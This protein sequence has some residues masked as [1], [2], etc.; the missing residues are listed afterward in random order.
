M[1]VLILSMVIAFLTTFLVTKIAIRFL[2]LIGVVGLDLHKREKPKLP[3]SGGICVAIG[4][5][6]GLLTYIGIQTFVY[7]SAEN[8]LNFLAV[9]CSVLLVVGV[10]FIDDLNVRSRLTKTKEGLRDIRVGLPQRKWLL[11]LPAAIPLMV[12]GAG[13]TTM[14]V[15]FIGNVNFGVIYPLILVPIGLVGASNAVNL[16][17][18]F[19]GSEA[20]MG[21]VYMLGLG[22]YGLLHGSPG[23][24]I[25]LI[26]F[27]SLLAFL[28][29][30][31]YPAKILP[32]DSLTYLLGS[33][34]AAGVIVGDM[35]KIGVIVLMPFVIEFLLKARSKFK[36]S[37]LGKLR[38]DGKLDPPYGKKIYSI[39]HAI[40]NLK[41]F[42]EYQ[43]SLILIL[44][45]AF[46]SLIPFLGI[47]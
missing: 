22:L 37:C 3:A 2:P 14:A 38:K 46:F 31:W 11:T 8:T 30:N 41:R 43:V 44:I 15:P 25:F 26:S 45:A 20:G 19:N 34:V 33:T 5:I 35:E 18:G 1:I 42:Y 12:V 4:L 29:Y 21:V 36:A 10:G 28:K 9:V 7:F 27:A 32:G 47:V 24:V 23:A 6:A 13:D 16:L 39:T 40:M 17:G